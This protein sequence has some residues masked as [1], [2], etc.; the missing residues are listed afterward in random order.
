MPVFAYSVLRD[1]LCVGPVYWTVFLWSVCVQ[2]LVQLT[3]RKQFII[4]ESY[5]ITSHLVVFM[6]TILYRCNAV[7]LSEYK[8]RI[9]NDNLI[10]KE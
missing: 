9:P 8:H 1:Y 2:T 7:S 3:N 6:V 4:S 10:I 5:F